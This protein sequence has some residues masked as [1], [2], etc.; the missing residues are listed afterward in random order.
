MSSGIE[1]AIISALVALAT[2]SF[3]GYFSWLKVKKD[4][5]KWLIDLKANYNLELLK[6]VLEELKEKASSVK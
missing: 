6:S 3:T 1:S 2:A 4:E 5:T